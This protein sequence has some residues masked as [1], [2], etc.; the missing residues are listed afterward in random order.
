MSDTKNDTEPKPVNDQHHAFER[1]RLRR[2]ALLQ[3]SR[4][5]RRR[6]RQLSELS[7]KQPRVIDADLWLDAITK[8][9]LY[10]SSVSRELEDELLRAEQYVQVLQQQ[11]PS[12]S[13]SWDP[14]RQ[15]EWLSWDPARPEW[16][17]LRLRAEQPRQPLSPEKLFEPVRLHLEQ[18]HAQQQQPGSDPAE[19][20][21]VASGL[22][23]LL[24]DAAFAWTPL[25]NTARSVWVRRLYA[26]DPLSQLEVIES[27]AEQ[28]PQ[29][30]MAVCIQ[31]NIQPQSQ[32]IQPQAQAISHDPAEV[33]TVAKGMASLLASDTVGS[34]SWVTALR[35]W[36]ERWLALDPLSLGEAIEAAAKE[37]GITPYAVCR[38][39]NILPPGMR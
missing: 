26:L 5:A 39:L 2:E 7:S 10:L 36:E 15:V 21:A 11:P 1:G 16:L 9:L 19:V 8:E 24:A 32:P 28:H 34:A 18:L 12:P 30:A 6:V 22:R 35:V 14:T 29:D 31:L 38:Q 27:V 33:D 37:A 4:D 23:G 25:W 13:P 17:Q 3:Q 20:D